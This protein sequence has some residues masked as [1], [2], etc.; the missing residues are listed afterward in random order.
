MS[1]TRVAT[2]ESNAKFLNSGIVAGRHLPETFFRAQI[3]G[4]NIQKTSAP[5]LHSHGRFP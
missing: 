4:S 5:G 3:G 1:A 2:R